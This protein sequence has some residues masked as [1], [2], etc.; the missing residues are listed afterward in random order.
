MAL[1]NYH[2]TYDC[3]PTG[4]FVARNSNH[5]IRRN[6]DFSPHVRLLNYLEQSALFNAANLQVACI[7]DPYG[8]AANLTVTTTRLSVFLCPS[9]SDPDWPMVDANGPLQQAIAPGN[10]YFASL[11]SSLEIRANQRGGSP[12]GVFPMESK[13]LGIRDIRDGT[14]T[15]IAFG[16]WRIG[17]GDGSLITVPTDIVFLGQYPPGVKRFTS[18]MTMPAGAAAF[19][20]W[21]PLCSGAIR[22]LRTEHTPFLGRDWAFG[23]MGSSVG[24]VLLPPNPAYPNCSTS[25]VSVD[26]V[27]RPGMMGMSSYHDGGAN[28]LMCDGAVRF[29]KDSTNTPVVWALGSRAQGDIVSEGSY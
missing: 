16:E 8:T 10:S 24:N 25:S 2:S 15:T 11:G 26:S 22:T 13:R 6:G 7:N 19:Q 21:L 14:S 12:N 5:S 20:Q 4:S 1:Q 3:F 29:L 17:S 18:G 23:L 28:I 27:Q 9:C